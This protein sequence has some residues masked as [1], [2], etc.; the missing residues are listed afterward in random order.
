[1]VFR[2]QLF[3]LLSAESFADSS[4]HFRK[5]ARASW[6]VRRTETRPHQSNVPEPVQ[7]LQCKVSK[8]ED[9][10]V[11]PWNRPPDTEK[12]E[13]E[14]VRLEKNNTIQHRHGEGVEDKLTILPP[15]TNLTLKKVKRRAIPLTSWRLL[16]VRLVLSRNLLMK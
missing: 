5:P 8:S 9:E 11:W 7:P 4:D 10:R 2:N 6:S 1:M 14:L 16:P 12:G 15:Y 13:E 3:S